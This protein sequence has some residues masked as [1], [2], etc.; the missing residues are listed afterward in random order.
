M[1]LSKDVYLL[2]QLLVWTLEECLKKCS[3]HGYSHIATKRKESS[4]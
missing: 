3:Y 1:S 4:I 2:S